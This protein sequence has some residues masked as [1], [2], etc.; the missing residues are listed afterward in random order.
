MAAQESNQ[1]RLILTLAIGDAYQRMW[2]MVRPRWECY[3]ERVGAEIAV[4]DRAESPTHPFFDKLIQCERLALSGQWDRICF[5]D[6][7]EVPVSG[8]PDIFDC[9]PDPDVFYG[10]PGNLYFRKHLA[11]RLRKIGRHW[12]T[13][14]PPRYI[15]GGTFLFGPEH[16]EVFHWDRPQL[17]CVKLGREEGV[18]STRLMECSTP[19]GD[20]SPRWDAI[21]PWWPCHRP[22]FAHSDARSAGGKLLHFQRLF[23]RIPQDRITDD[24]PAELAALREAWT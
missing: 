13:G 10:V 15:F 4:I 20:M 14:R 12:K 23:S 5:A 24:R 1:R 19:F 3:A 6:C 11:R 16:A 21:P 18:I 9:H 2:S 7:D 22:F 8:A 17:M